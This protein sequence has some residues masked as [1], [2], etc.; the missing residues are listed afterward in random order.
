V[1]SSETIDNVLYSSEGITT[2]SIYVYF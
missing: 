1:K 2:T